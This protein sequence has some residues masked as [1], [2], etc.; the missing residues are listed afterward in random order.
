MT[1]PANRSLEMRMLTALLDILDEAGNGLLMGE[2]IF[3]LRRR[4]LDFKRSKRKKVKGMEVLVKEI[5]SQTTLLEIEEYERNSLEVMTVKLKPGVTRDQWDESVLPLTAT[6]LATLSHAP[7]CERESDI[8]SEASFFTA[9]WL[10]KDLG[11]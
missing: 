2:I 4:G 6:A 10:P 3:K 7:S 5:A 8:A 11:I 1:A 9:R